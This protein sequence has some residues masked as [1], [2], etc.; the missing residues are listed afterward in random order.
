MPSVAIVH[1]YLTQ[2]GGAE[3]V[4]LEMT[5]AF[6]EATLYTTVF[7]PEATFDGFGDVNVE[8]VPWLDKVPVAR[9]DARVALPVLPLA[10][11]SIDIDADVVLCSSS[12]WSHGIRTRGKKVVYC[13]NPARWL[14][15]PD[16]YFAGLPRRLRRLIAWLLQPLRWWDA[17]AARS[18]EIYLAN[19]RNVAR[20]IRKTYGRDSKV[21]HPPRGLDTRGLQEPVD[22][23]EPG[24]YLTVSRKRGYKR[25]R[26]IAR[27]FA[28]G[29]RRLVQ[30]GGEPVD[31][32][33]VTQVT[34][35]SDAQ[36]RWLY[37]NA[38]ALIA[39]GDED[40]GLTPVECYAFGTPA[41]VLSAGGYLET[42]SPVSTVMV[43]STKPEAVR[44]AMD[45]LESR[46]WDEAA[47][48]EHAEKWSPASFHHQLHLLVEQ[49]AGSSLPTHA[50][51]PK[52][53]SRQRPELNVP[54]PRSG[55]HDEEHSRVA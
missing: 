24:F 54:R 2:R 27:A 55:E 41:I 52:S 26:D 5:R 20:R 51:S 9:H 17:R 31:S 53:D 32:D 4:A 36:L 23:L 14:Y 42:A 35:L 47:I 13:H 33:N 22:G 21:V 15:Q 34:G 6:P 40:F 30:V 11:Q 8:V 18:C 1:D 44:A 49:A 19:S 10:V 43:E 39:I 3:R 50:T 28:G 38:R 12:G 16:A 7:N 45:E 48:R 29:D 25:S 37:A 46:T